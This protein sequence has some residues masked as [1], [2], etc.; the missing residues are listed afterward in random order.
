M[1]QLLADVHL[2]NV[3]L[4][5]HTGTQLAGYDPTF[6]GAHSLRSGFVTEAGRQG[7]AARDAMAVSGHKSL[8]V[9]SG[10]FQAGA[11]MKNPAEALLDQ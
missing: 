7:V 3:G 11:V 2:G 8:A 9:F 4:L 5:D 10:K 1:M 6:F